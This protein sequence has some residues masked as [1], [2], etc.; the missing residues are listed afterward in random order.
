VSFRQRPR[1]RS[2]TFVCRKCRLVLADGVDY[3]W[4]PTCMGE[5]DWLDGRFPAWTCDPCDLL[6]NTRSVPRE[7]CPNCSR[8]LVLISKPLEDRGPLLGS[9]R[10]AGWAIFVMFLVAFAVLALID[11]D[12][13]PFLLSVMVTLWLGTSIVFGRRLATSPEFRALMSYHPTRVIHAIEHATAA[14]LGERG[15]RVARGQTA[16]GMFTLELAGA[17]E[18]YEQLS[19]I[20]EDA[21]A[22]AISRLRFGERELAA[23]PRCVTSRNAA[24]TLLTLAIVTAGAL[25]IAY[26]VAVPIVFAISV[27]A[28]IGAQYL[29]T[30]TAVFAQRALTAT[31]FASAT[32]T[33]VD[34]RASADGST[35]S[36][37]VM[38]DVVPSAADVSAVA[39]VPM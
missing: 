11:P 19:T 30:R 14:V 22:D 2:L 18:H 34:T 23:D 38:I 33:R 1:R 36:A 20:V 28:T 15:F 37:I 25:A 24:I 16:H 35:L 31:K 17:R 29:V 4:C 8:P 26:G 6:V 32:V 7:E 5:V 27:A 39:P 13:Y 12:A 3:T 21:A 10:G 9:L